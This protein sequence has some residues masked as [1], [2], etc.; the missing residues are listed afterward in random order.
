MVR[1]MIRHWT[2]VGS[3]AI[4]SGLAGCGSK[5]SGPVV[6]RFQTNDYQ[7]E[8]D[9]EQKRT[10][11]GPGLMRMVRYPDD[12][13][14]STGSLRVGPRDYGAVALKDRI[15]V[16]GGKVTVNGQERKPSAP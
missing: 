5:T 2:L 14:V 3:L 15:S 4:L 8:Y 7:F 11:I 13:E 1:R 12:I 16:V 10:T 6:Y 9:G